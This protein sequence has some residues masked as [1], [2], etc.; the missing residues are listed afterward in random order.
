MGG[1]PAG[2]PG[3]AK[4]GAGIWEAP[5]GSGETPAKRW[6]QWPQNVL[7]SGT[8]VPHLEQYMIVS[9]AGLRQVSLDRKRGAS[10]DT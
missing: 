5:T 1:A 10:H 7:L 6:P 2:T 3:A 8:A 4:T 9:P